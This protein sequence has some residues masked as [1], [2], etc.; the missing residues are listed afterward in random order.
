M[1]HHVFYFDSRA[2]VGIRVECRN[3]DC[4]A[5]YGASSG[6]VILGI[7]IIEGSNELVKK[8]MNFFDYIHIKG[9]AKL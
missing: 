9:D 1:P 8:A 2:C 5:D 3:F 6:N 4:L 7:L